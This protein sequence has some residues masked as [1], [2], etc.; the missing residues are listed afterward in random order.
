MLLVVRTLFCNVAF[1]NTLFSSRSMEG[2]TRLAMS[3]YL[4]FVSRLWKPKKNKRHRAW[5]EASRVV[6]KS[7]GQGRLPNR[8]KLEFS[9][10]LRST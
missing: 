8:T 6:A 7:T 3:F 1:L 5:Q 2:D 10:P 4:L 9:G